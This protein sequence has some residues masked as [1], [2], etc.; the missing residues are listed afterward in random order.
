MLGIRTAKITTAP[1]SRKGLC[2]KNKPEA[3][4]LKRL[5]RVTFRA[6]R[7]LHRPRLLVRSSDMS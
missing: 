6:N 7:S 4:E 1:H 2:T 5:L 3:R